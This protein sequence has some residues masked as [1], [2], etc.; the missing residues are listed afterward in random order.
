LV[1][2]EQKTATIQAFNYLKSELSS[3]VSDNA[4]AVDRVESNMDIIVGII[5]NG[6]TSVPSIL[7]TDP[8][9]YIN[10]F[11][12][13]RDLLLSNK[14]FIKEET[15]AFIENAYPTLSYN[16][17]TCARDVE[18]IV[19]AVVYDLTYSGN[20]ETLAASLAYYSGNTLQIPQSERLA[21]SG[22][23]RY[24]KSLVEKLSLNE[25][26]GI[27]PDIEFS[28][29]T[30][31]DPYV[32]NAANILK[33][34]RTFLIE[35]GIAYIT[36]TYPS[37]EYD[38]ATCRRDIGFIVDA[39]TYDILYDGNSQTA[40]A[41]DEYFSGGS[42][43]IPEGERVATANTFNFIKTAARSAVIYSEYTQLN[44][45][46]S[47]DITVPS[48]TE[49]E[50]VRVQ[51][52]FSIVVNIVENAYTSTITLEESAPEVLE[53]TAVTFHQYSLI[54]ASGHT[55]EWIGAG[56]NVNTALPY[57][58]GVPITENQVVQVNGGKVYFTGT[59]QRGDFRIGNDFVINQ[60]TGT[61]S[62]RTFTKS[63]F[64]VMTPYILA[65]GD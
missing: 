21:T 16:Q 43:Q 24:L 19:D 37:L 62:G 55:F 45:V 65:I 31:V 20:S 4:T 36:Q 50:A 11:K 22:S 63:L 49:D 47:R 35:E 40:D 5:T 29:P 32:L 58:G 14:N 57:L 59:D 13:A 23:Y 25:S 52:L 44:I 30:D 42:L 33:Q 54:T 8:L 60:N 12:N 61:I 18:Y 7:I 51:D 1:I 26:I 46:T 41:A 6:L 10:E 27:A 3:L 64:A 34:N 15:I 56:T 53:D 39:V 2:A 38:N 28:S 9:G 17:E 48:A